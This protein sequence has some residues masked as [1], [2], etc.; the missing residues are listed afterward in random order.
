MNAGRSMWE[1]GAVVATA[2]LHPIFVEVLHQRAVFI[3]LALA[4]WLLYLGIRVREDQAVLGCWGFRTRGLGAALVA[5]SV[6]AVVAVAAMGSIAIPR[7]MLVFRWQ[8]L[9]LL[10]LYPIW[11]TAGF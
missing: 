11:G 3:G 1:V 2:V 5:T 9:L 6:F 8:M 4:G 7:N 10:V